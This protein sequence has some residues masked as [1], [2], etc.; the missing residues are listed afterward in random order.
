MRTWIA[1]LTAI[2][3]MLCLLA[4]FGMAAEIAAGPL[5][6]G[7]VKVYLSSISQ[8]ETV[9]VTLNGSY[10]LGEDGTAFTRGEKLEI[11]NKGGSLVMT[12][13]GGTQTVGSQLKLRRHDT[14]GENG[15]RIAE[16]RYP[17]NLYPGDLE[18]RAK[19][20]V[21]Q[22]IVHVFMEDYLPGVV[23]YEMSEE[24][25]LEAL[26]AQ[27]I[28]ARTYTLKKISMQSSLYDVVDTTSDQVY[29]GTPAALSKCK[30]AVEETAGII[31]LIDGDYMATFYTA[32][33]G[34]QTESVKN[35]WGSTAYPYLIVKEDPYDLKNPASIAKSVSFYK[36]GTT[37]VP[38]LTELLKRE[39]AAK[40]SKDSVSITAING[41]R[42][43]SPKYEDTSHVYRKVTVDMT[44]K[45]SG[46]ISLSL[47]YFS[48]VESLCG[49]SI[50]SM[51][52]E[53]LTVTQTVGGYKLTA[54][55]YGHGIGMSQRGAQQMA[56]EGK[57][58]TEILEFYYPGIKQTR[59]TL[60]RTLLASLDGTGNGSTAID[61]KSATVSL[62]N[63]L[64]ALKLRKS[65]SLSASVLA[66]IPHG[67][68]I[69]VLENQGEWMR[70]QYGL[71]SGYVKS[72]YL[73]MESE[74]EDERASVT[75]GSGTV[76]VSLPDESQILN[77]RASP[78]TAASVLRYL[79]N[80][81]TLSILE[82]YTKWSQ[83]QFGSIIGYVMN[84]Y[85]RDAEEKAESGNEEEEETLTG[86]EVAIVL[87]STGLNLRLSASL[88]SAV[89]M[90]LPQGS[91]LNV[92]GSI[93][94][95]MLPVAL[96]N[97]EGYVA[98][99]Y[100]YVTI[101]PT[102]SPE[103]EATPTPTPEPFQLYAKVNAENG[104]ILRS[105]PAQQADAI[106]LLSNGTAL[107]I[108][109]EAQS[110]FF[111]VDV[112]DVQGY[113]SESY[114]TFLPGETLDLQAKEENETGVPAV[115]ASPVPP[116][117]TVLSGEK[118]Y[119]SAPGGL[120]LRKEPST[121][122]GV[123]AVIGYGIEVTVLG[124]AVDGFY[125]VRMGTLMGYL[126]ADYVTMGDAPEGKPSP[127]Q[128]AAPTVQITQ[129]TEIYD[130][131]AYRVVVNSAS[132]LNLR[133]RPSV[134]SEVIYVLP[135]GMVLTVTG[136]AEGNFLKVKW[137]EYEGYVSSEFVSPIE[138][139]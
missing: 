36:D 116:A 35:A 33:N 28:A 80:G 42:L 30:K 125:P 107:K 93:E 54:R 126:S 56:S 39:A 112:G 114:L 21:L 7:T 15:F 3:I 61:A 38:A 70:V 45:G 5:L 127:T 97:I 92:K 19:G 57:T 13:N 60:Q 37:S 52:N 131:D 12:A 85:I 20:T 10:T 69:T 59:Y 17:D 27:A 132:G 29:N 129:G 23:A 46:D 68:G 48:Q 123:E 100:V 95:G 44:I 43:T 96:G 14:T 32:S 9:H 66:M 11:K 77:L 18:I 47:D 102:P 128:T 25:P 1:R 26:K 88:R 91:I 55:R 81:E 6:S 22:I 133:A 124:E 73:H 67:T 40:L 111:P 63:S 65:P 89:M 82:R 134:N 58:Y 122:S 49:L 117:S 16:A 138:A 62:N 136:N 94:T 105:G 130:D 71:L 106:R 51:Q 104:L 113:V 109:G 41:V 50:N 76:I 79:R 83:V 64:D 103:P 118:A 90:V 108:T 121:S 101:M 24:F 87:P 119:V 84:D 135:Y 98:K 8:L 75:S 53:T 139:K 86:D 120:N 99:E 78:T 2:A 137:D 74:D 115:T 110:G 72:E 31:G 4:T 34:G